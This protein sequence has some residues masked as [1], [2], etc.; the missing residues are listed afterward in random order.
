MA[1]VEDGN[2]M[3]VIA[4][5]GVKGGVGKSTFAILLAFKMLK[6]KKKVVLCDCDVECPNDY[7]ILNQRLKNPKPIYQEFPKLNEEKCKKCGLCS[8]VCR[9][10]AI[11]WVKNNY[12]KFI[13]DLCISC[14]ACWISCPNKAI[15]RKKEVAG[16]FFVNK[17]KNNFWLITGKSKVGI[18][19]T[20][21]IVKE[22]KERAIKFAKKIGA[23]YL[24]IDTSP[25]THC[26]VIQ[27]LLNSDKV[28]AVTEP[29]PLG[30]YDLGVILELTKKLNLQA[31]IVLNK[32]DVGNKKEIEKIA[33]K[34]KSKISI[35]IPYSEELIKAYCTG[36]L[37]KIVI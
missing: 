30:A 17:I 29:T 26:N 11:F 35:E 1:E 6:Q 5:T 2:K 3:Q 27:A 31:E 34:F 21:P 7:L 18:S 4:S 32:A 37:E 20:G 23:D 36:N 8:E 24:I 33:R 9:E 28:Y 16:K 10:H 22:V 15:N 12:P 13:L 25:G 14:G 19:E